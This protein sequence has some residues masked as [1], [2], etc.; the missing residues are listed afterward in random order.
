MTEILAEQ[1]S[2]RLDQANVHHGSD[3]PSHQST[4]DGYRHERLPGKPSLPRRNEELTRSTS[5]VSLRFQEAL[6]KTGLEYITCTSSTMGL[7]TAT[8][9]QV[10]ED[11]E[12]NRPASVV[13]LGRHQQVT[14]KQALEMR[15]LRTV[16]GAARQNNCLWTTFEWMCLISANTVGR[17]ARSSR[18][19]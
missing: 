6:V 14:K 17:Y 19:N 8:F 5:A 7:A 9:F 15:S 11:E 16:E 1:P 10:A 3:R 13:Q 4:S 18:T 12:N 2:S